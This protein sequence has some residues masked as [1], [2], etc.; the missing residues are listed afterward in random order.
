MPH[1][2][3]PALFALLLTGLLTSFALFGLARV[4]FHPDE[5]TQLYTSQD[6]D[7]L[8]R[9]PL[10]LA[11]APPEAPDHRQKLRL[12]DAPLTRYWLGLWRSLAGQPANLADWD[13]SASWQANQ[14]AGALPSPSLLFAGRLAALALYPVSLVLI[15]SIGRS[16]A[17]PTAGLLA[18]LLLGL[19]SLALLHARRAMAEAALLTSVLFALWS[20]LHTGHRPWLAGL[21]L[22]AA[23]NAKQTAILLLPVA[24]LAALWHTPSEASPAR[25]PALTAS[26]ALAQ[27]LGVF[28]LLTLALNPVFWRAPL[29]AG[30]QALLARQAL[31]A[32]Q[33]T[34]TQRLAP[35]HA[36]VSQSQRAAALLA[37]LYFAPPAFAEWGN[38]RA[39]T[40]AAE[41]A[42]LAIPGHSLLRGLAGGALQFILALC[43]A[44]FA[45]LRLRHAGP[46]Q[47]RALILALLATLCLALGHLLWIPL[48][49]QRYV[50]PLVPLSCLWQAY[51]L[52]LPMD[53][54][55]RRMP[56]AARV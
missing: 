39:E 4:P 41:A 16:L 52:S 24:M 17:G 13:W 23:F 10:S 2:S 18:L 12:L 14:A 43:G 21:G 46:A 48:D 55:L 45:L 51:A 19:N 40:A 27:C 53:A 54:A 38:Y 49:W 7:L 28:I 29:M 9:T 31:A 8:W 56:G 33:Q 34:D 30:R 20:F 6:F 32:A 25:R 26:L 42:Y 22:A 1:P 5:A 15:F 35:E 11:W 36:L 50:I 47:R 37:N 3:R 44:L